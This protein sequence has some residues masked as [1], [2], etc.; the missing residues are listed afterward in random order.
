MSGLFPLEYVDRLS[1]ELGL[2]FL[3]TP[4]GLACAGLL[5]VLYLVCLPLLYR[6]KRIGRPLFVVYC[7]GGIVLFYFSGPSVLSPFQYVLDGVGWA[8]DGAL[9]VFMYFSQIKDRFV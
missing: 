3:E 9:L 6:L 4:L 1:E 5:C 8:I 2:G 7:I